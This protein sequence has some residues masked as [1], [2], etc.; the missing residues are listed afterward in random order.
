M[1]SRWQMRAR[2]LVVSGMAAVA[3]PA[4][5]DEPADR[6]ISMS[7]WAGAAVDRSVVAADTGRPLHDG[8]PLIGATALGNVRW[9]A[10]GG[11]VDATPGTNGD[12]RLSIGVLLGVQPEVDRIRIQVLGEAGRHRFSDVGGTAARAAAMS[13]TGRSTCRP[14][15]CATVSFARRASFNGETQS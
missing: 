2:V 5:A 13:T 6:G 12:G 10:L 7:A 15:I 1:L 11:T 8:A 9:V 4:R 3:L 14:T